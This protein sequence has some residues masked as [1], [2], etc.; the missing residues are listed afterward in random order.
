M[1]VDSICKMNYVYRYVHEDAVLLKR[2][3]CANACIPYCRVMMIYRPASAMLITIGMYFLNL[4]NNLLLETT[5][6]FILI[7]MFPKS[8]PI[9]EFAES[10]CSM[11]KVIKW[12]VY[13]LVNIVEE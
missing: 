1:K 2:R 11:E 5:V 7:V 6:S 13:L 4:L 12:K 9:V 8:H 3:F 10:L